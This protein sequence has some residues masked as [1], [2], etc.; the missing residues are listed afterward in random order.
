MNEELAIKIL[1][2]ESSEETIQTLKE[3]DCFTDHLIEYAIREARLLAC[4]ALERQIPK[5]PKEDG[6]VFCPICGRDILMS[7][8]KYC[9]DCGQKIDWSDWR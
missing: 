6:W 3:Y 5:K 2:P 1:H 7:G 8:F 4:E 9:P